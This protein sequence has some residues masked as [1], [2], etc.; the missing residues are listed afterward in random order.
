MGKKD[1]IVKQVV[2]KFNQRSKVGIKKY[3]TTLEENNT[4]NFLVHLQEE[5]MDAI[6]YTQKIISQKNEDIEKAKDKLIEVLYCQVVDLS[7]MSKIELGDD[8]IKEIKRLK[9]IIKNGEY[10][11]KN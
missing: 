10:G 11:D 6:L 4:D 2:D 8:V 7:M 3:G 5:L 9:K 1:K